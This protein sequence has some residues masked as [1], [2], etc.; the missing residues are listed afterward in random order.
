MMITPPTEPST[1]GRVGDSDAPHASEVLVVAG[2]GYISTCELGDAGVVIGRHKNCDIVVDHGAFANRHA[3]VRTGT[4]ATVQ[5]LGTSQGTWIAG[6]NHRGGPPAILGMGETFHVGPYVF[7]VIRAPYDSSSFERPGV[8]RVIDPTLASASQLIKEIS[9]GAVSVMINGEAGVGKS[10]LA[11]ALHRLSGRTR[12]PIALRRAVRE[13][14]ASP[15]ATVILDDVDELP[16]G[17]QAWLRGAIE[18]LR[19]VQ[20]IAITSRDM[21]HE[22]AAG[23]FRTDL[24]AILHGITL[25]VPPL[26]E[27]T[28]L[29]GAL[30]FQFL[31]DS[32]RGRGNVWLSA[33][34]LAKLQSH[35]W[36]GNVRELRSVIEHSATIA[37]GGR[38]SSRD[39]PW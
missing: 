6:S 20:V 5:D 21:A 15:G 34:A 28:S 19:G 22:V 24:Y 25:L 27:R 35:S 10:V 26:R 39:L 12:E 38:I 31:R 36:P 2:E 4:T 11:G 29:I 37:R 13:L 14:E 8:F 9:T 32:I 16:L 17:T 30:S 23:R 7:V 3:L 33:N 18:R 1:R